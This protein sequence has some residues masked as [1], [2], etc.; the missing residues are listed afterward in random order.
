[1]QAYWL[2]FQGKPSGCVEAASEEDAKR[3]GAESMG[4]EVLE[5]SRLP[6]PANPRIINKHAYRDGI[7]CPS[8]CYRPEQCK[9]KTCC[10]E[11]R[12]CCD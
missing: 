9:G 4:A 11:R 2:K 7:T 5:C 3:I 10:P 8:F 6:Y 1:M 12:S